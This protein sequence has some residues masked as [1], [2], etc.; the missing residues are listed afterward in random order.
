MSEFGLSMLLKY[1]GCKGSTPQYMAPEVYDEQAGVKCDVWSLGISLLEMAEGKNPYAG[2]NQ[3]RLVKE[4]CFGA[5]PLLSSSAWSTGFVDFVGKC[6]VRDVNER[7]SV[8]QL[9]EVRASLW[10]DE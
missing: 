1:S 9:M 10:R 4:V 2:L 5:I 3:K 8:S 6:F 7:W